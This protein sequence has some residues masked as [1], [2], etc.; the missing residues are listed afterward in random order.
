MTVKTVLAVALIS[1]CAVSAAW[2]PGFV[3]AQTQ[4][5]THR[6]ESRAELY[7]RNLLAGKNVPCRTNA[8]CAALGVAALEAGRIDGHAYG[9]H[10]RR[11]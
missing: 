6:T 7:R 10:G 11:M 8:S 2:V 9:R 4:S 5:Q 1:A 3:R